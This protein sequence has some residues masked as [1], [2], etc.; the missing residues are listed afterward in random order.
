M[1]YQLNTPHK[2]FHRL[3]WMSNK[4]QILDILAR[5]NIKYLRGLRK[6]IQKSPYGSG[7]SRIY[8]RYDGYQ[9][10]V[11]AKTINAE[12]YRRLINK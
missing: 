3:Y 5:V 7:G 4:S 2:D 11:S 8:L 12:L 9:F 10:Q 1:S 6:R